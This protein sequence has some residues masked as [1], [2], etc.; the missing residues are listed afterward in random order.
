MSFYSVTLNCKINDGKVNV[1]FLKHKLWFNFR[2][3]LTG[4][5][6]IVLKIK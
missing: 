5:N 4:T 6:N 1:I 3:H 2:K